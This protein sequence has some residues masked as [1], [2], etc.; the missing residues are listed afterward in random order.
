MIVKRRCNADQ[1]RLESS[2]NLICLSQKQKGPIPTKKNNTKSR[3]VLL[4]VATSFNRQNY[5]AAARLGTS[6]AFRLKCRFSL[7]VLNL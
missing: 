1:R 6:K 4:R 5:L 2:T 7:N 3:H